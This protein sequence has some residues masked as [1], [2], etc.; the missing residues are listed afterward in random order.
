MAFDA[1]AAAPEAGAMRRLLWPLIL[2]SALA[3]LILRWKAPGLLI[4]GRSAMAWAALAGF[5][6]LALRLASMAFEAS[7]REL[8]WTRL[9][10][11]AVLLVGGL[12]LVA[13]PS[14]LWTQVKLATGAGLE[15]ALIA[16]LIW[17]MTHIAPE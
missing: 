8:R 2:A 10:L 5:A 3:G 12:G 6:L 16:F 15:L 9:L 14:P 1:A 11:P 4:H 17:R 7:R 13:R